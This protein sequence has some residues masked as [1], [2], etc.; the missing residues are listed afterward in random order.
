M[1]ISPERRR[2]AIVGDAVL[3]QQSEEKFAA[4][5]LALLNPQLAKSAKIDLLEQ[6]ISDEKE[7]LKNLSENPVK[8]GALDRANL[9]L[10]NLRANRQENVEVN[11]EAEAQ[12][13]NLR[14]SFG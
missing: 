12:D 11:P 10:R 4:L 8:S 5:K 14:A 3:F 13:N 2:P 7:I 9:W 6:F 1:F